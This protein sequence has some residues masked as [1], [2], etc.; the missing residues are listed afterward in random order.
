[1]PA[2][3]AL[4]EITIPD[5]TFPTLPEFEAQAPEFDEDAPSISAIAQWSEPAY[6]TEIIGDVLVTVRKMLAGQTG[7]PAPIEDAIYAR[8]RS[9]EFDTARIAT[10]QAFDA[11][12]GRGFEMP[13]GMLVEQVNVA[14]EQ[15]SLRSNSASRELSIEVARINIENLRTAV[16]QGISAEQVLFNISNNAAQRSFEMARARLDAEVGLFNAKVGL[17]NARQEG[18]SVSAQVYRNLLDAKLSELQV[19]RAQIEGAQ[20]LS[21]LNESKARIYASK[22]DA[23]RVLVDRYRVE[24]DGARTKSEIDRSRIEAYR[25]DVEAYKEGIQARKVE[26]DAYEAQVRAEA[27]KVGIVEAQAN[28][29]AA[30]VRAAESR[31]NVAVAK[32]R[33]RIDGVQASVAKFGALVGYERERISA[34]AQIA[35][36]KVNAYTADVQRYSAEIGANT[37]ANEAQIRALDALT[38][39]NISQYEIAVQRYNTTLQ[40]LVEQARLQAESIRAAG[41]AAAQLAAGAMSA[42][43]VTANIRGGGNATLN[44][45]FGTDVN[46]S[47]EF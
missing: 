32:V 42:I 24:M 31:S 34:Q 39:T 3:D 1:L 30:T 33:A 44:E 2:L 20:A 47:T 21:S 41:A 22:I 7:L 28:A 12:A 4:A 36:S 46:Y 13:P 27:A 14:H 10:D 5:F 6:Q 17:F 29:F 45:S 9:R 19:Y 37:A 15:A 35:A 25:A 16:A 23:I 8:A 38:R 18:Y 26:F 11:W 40:A 43:S